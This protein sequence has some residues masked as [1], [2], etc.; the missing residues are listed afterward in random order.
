MKFIILKYWI[1]LRHCE[2][3]EL[4]KIPEDSCV[5][6]FSDTLPTQ[7]QG[8]LRIMRSSDSEM[9]KSKTDDGKDLYH[10]SE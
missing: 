1:H 6:S 7:P 9:I 4:I 10:V 5:L 8:N 2:Y 3:I